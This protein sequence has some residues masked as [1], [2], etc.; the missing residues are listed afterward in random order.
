MKNHLL[1]LTIL[2]AGT[3]VVLPS[4]AQDLMPPEAIPVEDLR[5]YDRYSLVEDRGGP[6]DVLTSDQIMPELCRYQPCI[7]VAIPYCESTGELRL[8]HSG[9]FS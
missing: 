6:N 9:V 3:A 5:G 4:V 2:I 7:P 1:L 8:A